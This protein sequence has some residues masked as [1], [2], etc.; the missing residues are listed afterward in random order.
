MVYDILCFCYSSFSLL[1]LSIFFNF[2]HPQ[3]TKWLYFSHFSQT[4]GFGIL[5]LLSSV[6]NKTTL[7]KC[8]LLNFLSSMLSVKEFM[9][10]KINN[11]DFGAIYFY[12]VTVLF[13]K[14]LQN[15]FRNSMKACRTN[16]FIE[17]ASPREK[18]LQSIHG[19]PRPCWTTHLRILSGPFV[20]A[21]RIIRC[22]RKVLIR[23]TAQLPVFF[24]I[25][26]FTSQPTQLRSCLPSR[27]WSSKCLT[28]TKWTQL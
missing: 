28:N 5:F 21:Y 17:S 19:Q 4:I 6:K 1:I 22:N 15:L 18:G 10:L 24:F 13:N 7:S 23:M 3:T 11:E 16:I 12:I 9:M 26:N 27:A 2:Y 20:S 14:W 8:R 25:W